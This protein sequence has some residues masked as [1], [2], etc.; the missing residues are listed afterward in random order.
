MTDADRLLAVSLVSVQFRSFLSLS[1]LLSLLSLL[2]LLLSFL[3]LLLGPLLLY[4]LLM[5]LSSLLS[6]LLD[7]YCHCHYCW[8]CHC[9]GHCCNYSYC[10]CH[11]YYCCCCCWC[12]CGRCCCCGGAHKGMITSRLPP[13]GWSLSP[14]LISKSPV[15]V[16][17]C[18]VFVH[19]GCAL[20]CSTWW[21]TVVIH[22]CSCCDC[23]CRCNCSCCMLWLLF[24][25]GGCC[26]PSLV[27]IHSSLL[28]FGAM[29]IQNNKKKQQHQH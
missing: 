16:V 17:V 9:H 1:L 14:Q 19:V 23:C 4:L 29:A 27:F 12:F 26:S 2:C 13:S 5:S 22:S 20:H 24:N 6:L 7:W 8:Y 21:F 18:V 11:C 28:V 25:V 3:W 10:H 15:I